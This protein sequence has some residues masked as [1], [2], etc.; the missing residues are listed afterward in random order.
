[1]ANKNNLSVM[2]RNKMST[3]CDGANDQLDDL[4]NF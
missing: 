1:M 3:M 2:A 4:P